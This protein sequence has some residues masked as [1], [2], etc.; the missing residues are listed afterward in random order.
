LHQCTGSNKP[1]EFK[2]EI[3][4]RV[5]RK[6]SMLRIVAEIEFKKI[7]E[8]PLKEVYINA[9]IRLNVGFLDRYKR[10]KSSFFNK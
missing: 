8:I 4:G 2:F 3:L 5:P 1:E 6:S 10:I 7:S 9:W